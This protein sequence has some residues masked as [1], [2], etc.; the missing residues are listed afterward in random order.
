MTELKEKITSTQ[1]HLSK[2]IPQV[3]VKC[4]ALPV[5]P[6]EENDNDDDD[7]DVPMEDFDPHSGDTD[8]EEIECK[9]DIEK[10][11]EPSPRKRPRRS[12]RNIEKPIAPKIE[13]EEEEAKEEETKEEEAQEEDE[14]TPIDKTNLTPKEL[15]KIEKLEEKARR[16]KEW[17]KYMESIQNER[18]PLEELMRTMNLLNCHVCNEEQPTFLALKKHIEQT[19]GASHGYIYCC[20]RKFNRK[21]AYDH[22]KYHLNKEAF[23]CDIC[24]KLWKSH[25][26]LK[27]H[28]LNTHPAPDKI[29]FNCETCGRGFV[30]RSILALHVKSH[31]PVAERD[32]QCAECPK[33]FHSRAILEKH[34]QTV[35]RRS[36]DHF[37]EICGKG[38]WSR[39]LLNVHLRSHQESKSEQCDICG[40]YFFNVRWHKK[41]VHEESE[42]VTCELCGKVNKKYMV[43]DHM[44]L[45][46]SGLVWKC[47]ICDK[48][49]KLKKTMQDHMNIHLG[50]RFDCHFCPYSAT[51]SGNLVKHMNQVHPKEYAQYR[52]NRFAAQTVK[53]PK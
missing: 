53:N 17:A 34:I 38:M 26:E 2:I 13:E 50:I 3:E 45:Y 43:H 9:P 4:E 36:T 19:H 12:T 5:A 35:H 52:A 22:M 24:G 31:L 27:A 46:H 32:H 18:K 49:F 16:K 23:K 29:L 21:T 20:E 41:R 25:R 28:L 11:E 14:E 51:S 39:G 47:E 8:S 40:K 15:A 10:L 42:L 37:C 30:S 6:K 44:K 7:D 48:E 1:L 33:G